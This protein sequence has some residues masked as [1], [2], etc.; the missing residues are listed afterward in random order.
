M[1]WSASFL[2]TVREIAE[3]SHGDE[4]HGGEDVFSLAHDSNPSST[5]HGTHVLQ[6]VCYL[7][8]SLT[9]PC[10]GWA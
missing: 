2:L 9:F 1:W 10:I 3:V 7:F 5:V 6:G 8:Y 4:E